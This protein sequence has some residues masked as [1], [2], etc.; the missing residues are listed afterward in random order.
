[1]TSRKPSLIARVNG[2][3]VTLSSLLRHLRI[4]LRWDVMEETMHDVVITQACAEAGLT[5]SEAEMNDHMDAF[6]RERRLFTEKVTQKW[7]DDH[8][9]SDDDFLYLLEREIKLSKLKEF[10][11]LDK[12]NERFAYERHRLDKVELYKIVVEDE[13]AA[14]E[15]IALLQEGA[16]FYQLAKLHSQDE[17]TRVKCGY[18]GIV[19]R[20]D[21]RAEIES[22][23]FGCREGGIAGPVKTLG[24]YQIFL[25]EKFYPATLDAET[26]VTLTDK[27]FQEWLEMRLQSA[28]VELLI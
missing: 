11:A 6:R 15:L 8:R 19:G 28:H 27:L 14:R 10:I 23:V 22:A 18:M 7:L 2:E 17:E 3:E 21:L 1:M 24:T 20:P 12:I 5:A 26:R 13:S 4:T 16:S 25:V 9:L